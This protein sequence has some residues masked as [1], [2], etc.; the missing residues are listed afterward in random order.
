MTYTIK[1]VSAT[2]PGSTT[3]VTKYQVFVEVDTVDQLT[4]LTVT[5][6]RL[7]STLDQ[8]AFD[9]VRAFTVA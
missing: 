4:G 3:P 6:H 2:V 7:V 1:Q 9:A 5:T 8:D